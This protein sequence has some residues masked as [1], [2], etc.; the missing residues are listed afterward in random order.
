M[1]T[2]QPKTFASRSACVEGFWPHEC[3]SH[4]TLPFFIGRTANCSNTWA[5]RTTRTSST[6]SES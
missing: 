3:W 2:P 1:V 4:V 6:L 5:S